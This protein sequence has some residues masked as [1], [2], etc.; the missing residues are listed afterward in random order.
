MRYKKI[1]LAVTG[2]A[3]FFAPLTSRAAELGNAKS[4]G[5][6]PVLVTADE[7]QYDQDLGLT[8]AKGHVELSQDDQILL[9]DTVTYN[10]RTDTVTASGHVSLVQP[11]GDVAFADFME[12][13]DNFRDGFV[14]DVRLLLSDRSRM[15]G[16]TARRVGGTR[17]ELRRGVYSPCELCAADPS[18]PPIWQ[19]K[20]AQIVSDKDLEIVEYR[21]A[22]MEIAGFPV[23]Y[24]P[25]MSHPDPSVKRASGFLAPVLG[26]DASNGFRFGIPYYQVLGP[27]KDLTF[28]PIFTTQGGTVFDGQYRERF[29]NGYLLTDTSVTVGSKSID[30]RVPDINA[31]NDDIRGHIYADEVWDLTER[32][33]VGLN[34]TATTDQTYLPRY[35]FPY[36][37]N[38]LT[39]HVFAENF[40]SASYG[41]ISAYGFQNLN[42]TFGIANEP[43]VLPIAG[44]TFTTPTDKLGGRWQLTGNAMNLMLPHTGFRERRL[45]AGASWRLPFN[46]P[47]GDRY[48]FSANLR[49]DGYSSDLTTQ[50]GF[51]RNESAADGRLFPQLALSWHYPWI[52]PGATVTTL[53]EP[54]AAIFAAPNGGNPAGIPNEDAQSFEFDETDLFRANRFPGFDRVD[55]GQRVD[56]GVHAGF[57]NPD[58]GSTQVLF[59]QSY[60]FQR[61][62]DFPVGAG[63]DR[64]RSDIV[65][66]VLISPSGYF[67]LFY[68]A[69]IDGQDLAMRRQEVGVSGG[70]ANLRA[71]VSYIATSSIPGL[72][73]VLPA[74]QISASVSFQLTPNWSGAVTQ[75]QNLNNGSSSLNSGLQLTYR[76]DCIAVTGTVQ[77][78]A[79]SFGDLRSGTSFLLTFVFRNLGD[80]S[81]NPFGS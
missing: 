79:I 80:V 78:S 28:R 4:G 36:T 19:I 51:P 42:P 18:R 30:P 23:F 25:Y 77:R 38:Y 27:D 34:G 14:K 73:S 8:V 49:G 65:G 64:Q 43:V 45:S 3:A 24:T 39:D 40:G 33:R 76:D 72:P 69:R 61:N 31:R 20:A 63:L 70:P 7:L 5:N 66:R 41:N 81:F 60:R 44:Y 13:R 35:H 52:R 59:G 37:T 16:N 48:Q 67:D 46:G 26:S 50:A 53:I 58:A 62:A 22:V 6:K 10:Q 1:M 9:A 71:S 11:S 57:Y 75:T 29:G 17:T 56:Y 21:D 47:F 55:V 32:W 68:R 54:I 74:T 12:L 15:A 2:L